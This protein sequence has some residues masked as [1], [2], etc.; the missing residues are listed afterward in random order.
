[1][2]RVDTQQETPAPTDYAHD[3]SALGQTQT[4][5]AARPSAKS[6]LQEDISNQRSRLI[7]RL[8]ELD[9]ISNQLQY[10]DESSCYLIRSFLEDIEESKRI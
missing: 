6:R 9:R 7:R 5:K 3:R 8:A 1:M 2:D 4:P 10:T